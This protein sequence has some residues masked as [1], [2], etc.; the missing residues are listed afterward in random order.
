[1]ERVTTS[2]TTSVRQHSRKLDM[3][4]STSGTE[5][6]KSSVLMRNDTITE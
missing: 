2:L 4:E 1:M 5:I 6:K 3:S